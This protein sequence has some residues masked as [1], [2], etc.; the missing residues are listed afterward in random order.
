VSYFW[1]LSWDSLA[2]E[3]EPLLDL[4][5]DDLPDGYG[6]YGAG[7]AGEKTVPLHT[8]AGQI[9]ESTACSVGWYDED[10]VVPRR[11]AATVWWGMTTS[12]CLGIGAMRRGRRRRAV[13]GCACPS[14]RWYGVI[15]D[16]LEGSR[17]SRSVSL[18][19]EAVFGG[20]GAETH[21]RGLAQSGVRAV[22]E[23]QQLCKQSSI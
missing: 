13:H 11:Q 10:V 20:E 17:F 18:P 15:S 1:S 4:G 14:G 9:D 7:N 2:D 8:H 19:G 5:F 23:G 21:G 22:R 16:A 3:Q 12:C 6:S